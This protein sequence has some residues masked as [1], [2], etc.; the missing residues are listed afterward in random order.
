MISKMSKLN[1]LAVKT[2]R[3]ALLNSLS[4]TGMVHIDV[5]PDTSVE[6]EV[7]ETPATDSRLTLLGD[8]MEYMDVFF[9]GK[10]ISLDT[11][12]RDM[13]FGEFLDSESKVDHAL[14][15][16]RDILSSQE[17][18]DKANNDILLLR[19]TI[20]RLLTYQYIDIPFAQAV[21]TKRTFVTMGTIPQENKATLLALVEPFDTVA[22]QFPEPNPLNGEQALVLCAE[23]RLESTLTDILNECGYSVRQFDD[24]DTALTLIDRYN[25]QILSLEDAIKSSEDKLLSLGAEYSILATS[26]DYIS[27]S[28]TKQD[29][30]SRMHTTSRTFWLTGYVPTEHTDKVIKAISDISP[31][32]YY[33]FD[34]IKEGDNPPTQTVNNKVV[35]QFEF[36]TNMYSPPNYRELDPNPVMSVFFLAFFGFIMADIGY[37][38]LLAIGGYILASRMKYDTGTRRLVWVLTLG[39]LSTILFGL[40][41]G[42]FFGYTHE[43]IALIPPSIMPSPTVE[44]EKLLIISLGIGAV[45]M[46]V[47]FFQK[48]LQLI[49]KGEV[50]D[51]IIDGFVWCVFFVGLI[52]A[53]L[54]LFADT[55]EL[56][57]PA[58]TLNTG[59]YI[60][61][62]VVGLEVL[63]SIRHKGL[64]KFL[65]MF[66]S[67]YNLIGYFSDLLSYARLFGLMLSG[68]IIA[69]IVVQYATP[70]L[71][72]SAMPIG[73]IIIVVGHLFNLAMGALGA[74]I[75]VSRLQYI[76]F[77]SRFYDGEGEVFSPIGRGFRHTYIKE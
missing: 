28:L 76:E 53:G 59:I 8:A 77:F 30:S 4:A 12:M 38:L 60:C 48:G 47:A 16:A 6:G 71:A 73:V 43:H 63:L 39:G 11:S 25:Q 62:G 41:F 51:G 61:A 31:S 5:A 58:D 2:D 37:G 69:G 54:G 29:I 3:D 40:L 68:N 14:E 33:V 50:V 23:L 21:S 17:S 13:S 10:K 19:N 52:V 46:M 44:Y 74:Y 9:K 20:T 1:L 32:A 34:E 45:Q 75:H 66:T 42:S 18:I 15:V 64:T 72:T 27:Y 24:N 36:V 35:R 26:Y 65:R 49:H 56:A 67:V 22:V 7:V 57:L 70:M 55:L